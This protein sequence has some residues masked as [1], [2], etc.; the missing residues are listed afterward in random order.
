MLCYYTSPNIMMRSQLEMIELFAKHSN[1]AILAK[2]TGPVQARCVRQSETLT[3]V[4]EAGQE[5]AFD[6]PAGYWIITNATN[7]QEQYALDPTNFHS[8][9]ET[10]LEKTPN[11]GQDGVFRPTGRV[12]AV[13]VTSEI[14]AAIGGNKFMAAWG[15]PTVCYE[16]DLLAMPLPKRNEVYRID[17]KSFAETMVLECEK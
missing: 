3:T 16:G 11:P 2:K 15:E 1:S 7:A 13:T 10:M 4:T 12:L 6:V 8:R 14:A 17:A 5:T 9:Y